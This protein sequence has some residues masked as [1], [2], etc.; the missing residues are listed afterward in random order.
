[1]SRDESSC[2]RPQRLELTGRGRPPLQV[3]G[4]L[5]EEKLGEARR[6]LPISGE[7][8]ERVFHPTENWEWEFLHE[9]RCFCSNYGCRDNIR[10]DFLITLLV[11]EIWTTNPAPFSVSPLLGSTASS[12]GNLCSA[13]THQ[14]CSCDAA[15]CPL[16][17][18]LDSESKFLASRIMTLSIRSDAKIFFVM[19]EVGMTWFFKVNVSCFI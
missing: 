7:P 8:I 13:A 2:G 3:A 15:T 10:N 11:L 5:W 19:A 6:F 12:R 1:M 9:F 16:N 14:R 17:I 18:F 4:C